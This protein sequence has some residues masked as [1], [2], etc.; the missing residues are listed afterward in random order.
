MFFRCPLQDSDVDRD[1]DRERDYAENSD[2]VASDYGSGEKKKK[3]KHKERKEKK[4][5]KKKKDDGDRDSSQEETTKVEHPRLSSAESVLRLICCVCLSVLIDAFSFSP[6]QP[7]EQKT[8]AQLAKEWGLEDV[9]HTFTEEDYR[10]LT[11]YKAFSQFMRYRLSLLFPC[12]VDVDCWQ[13][14]SVVSVCCTVMELQPHC[15]D[16]KEFRNKRR[17]ARLVLQNDRTPV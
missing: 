10:E 14:S 6:Q 8:S 3:R 15:S 13:T 17:D 9:D 12:G 5:K 16:Q 1:S 4:T 2:S 11:N 7:M